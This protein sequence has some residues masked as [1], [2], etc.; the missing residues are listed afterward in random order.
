MALLNRQLDGLT[1]LSSETFT[2]AGEDPACRL[3]V[4]GATEASGGQR[5]AWFCR[6]AALWA[7]M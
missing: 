4:G 6:A 5:W 3:S 7:P 2:L 1:L